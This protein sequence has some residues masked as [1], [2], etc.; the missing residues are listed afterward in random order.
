ML[1]KGNYPVG[2]EELPTDV[3]Q[4]DTLVFVAMRP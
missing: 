3:E 1:H 4:L 2:E